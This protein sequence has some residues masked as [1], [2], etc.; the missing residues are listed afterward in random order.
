MFSR[1]SSLKNLEFDEVHPARYCRLQT[2]FLYKVLTA[3]KQLQS[4]SKY[5]KG[6]DTD[7]IVN[8][9]IK[10]HKMSG[11]IQSQVENVLQTATQSLLVSKSSH[12]LYNLV[13][14]A[15][16][17]HNVPTP[18]IPAKLEE[19][20]RLFNYPTDPSRKSSRAMYRLG[21]Y[22]STRTRMKQKQLKKKQS[23]KSRSRSKTRSRSRSVPR[24]SSGSPSKRTRTSSSKSSEAAS[25]RS[26]ALE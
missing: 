12:N 24:S 10:Y 4:F 13:V 20:Q 14:P 2:S 3:L 25:S 18:I 7:T 16:A 9:M 23:R 17:I 26:D 11:D 6:A 21:M 5:C 15:A 8:F 22:S 1:K 19:I